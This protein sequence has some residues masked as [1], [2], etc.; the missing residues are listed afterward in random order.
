MGSYA[1]YTANERDAYK[2]ECAELEAE[3]KRLRG[4]G[5][6]ALRILDELLPQLGGIVLQDY[7]MLNEVMMELRALEV[8]DD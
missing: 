8:S 6:K 5:S 1:A 3:V 4:T 7:G 2:E